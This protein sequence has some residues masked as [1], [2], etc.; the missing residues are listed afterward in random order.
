LVTFFG[1][2]KKVTRPPGRIPGLSPR[3]CSRLASPGKARAALAIGFGFGFGATGNC[4]TLA[5]SINRGMPLRGIP[6]HNKHR[7]LSASGIAITSRSTQCR[8]NGH[9]KSNCS[10]S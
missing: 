10:L 1:E 7:T 4:K 5:R 9:C 3:Q 2:A 6:P 8:G